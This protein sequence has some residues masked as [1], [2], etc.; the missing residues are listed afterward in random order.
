MK[1]QGEIRDKGLPLS[2]GCVVARVCMFNE[3]RHSN[4]PLYRVGESGV[5][6]ELK[7]VNRA[8]EVAASRLDGIRAQV[9]E[10]VGRAE[11]EIFVAQKMI[12]E[13]TELRTALERIIRDE[14][15]QHL[16]PPVVANILI[17]RH[18]ID[19]IKPQNGAGP[20]R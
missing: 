15:W 2:E 18:I 1:A 16:V 9:A 4:L 17:K 7:R 12:L 11:A 8:I 6:G 14:P 10:S 3:R 20:Q 5:E 13:D 19:R